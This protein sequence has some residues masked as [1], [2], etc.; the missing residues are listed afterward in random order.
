MTELI[1]LKKDNTDRNKLIVNLVFIFLLIFAIAGMFYFMFTYKVDE[2]HN[3]HFTKF[4]KPVYLDE[5]KNTVIDENYQMYA[6]ISNDVYL[7]SHNYTLNKYKIIKAIKENKSI[8]VLMEQLPE[9]GD[10]TYIVYVE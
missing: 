10:N 6:F 2:I 1:K 9:W 3:P 7:S 4:I 5:V 8:N